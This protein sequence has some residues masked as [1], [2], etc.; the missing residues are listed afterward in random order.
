MAL[1]G[2]RNSSHW[3]RH[4]WFS[5]PKLRKLMYFCCAN[6][7]LYLGSAASRLGYDNFFFTFYNVL[8]T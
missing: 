8:T 4:S 3:D 7:T 2:F 1:C 6:L 5:M